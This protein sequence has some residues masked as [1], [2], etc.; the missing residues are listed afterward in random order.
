[1]YGYCPQPSF[2]PRPYSN[3]SLFGTFYV[4][5]SPPAGRKHQRETIHNT[6]LVSPTWRYWKMSERLLVIHRPHSMQD[7][8]SCLDLLGAV[9]S[10]RLGSSFGSLGS[11]RC[12]R[13]S[14]R[15]PRS[16]PLHDTV[17]KEQYRRYK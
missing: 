3:S 14:T 11:L 2:L 6:Y 13:S 16:C 9:V 5:T 8:L 12:Y 4:W 15:D 7:S 10:R 1:M 17:T